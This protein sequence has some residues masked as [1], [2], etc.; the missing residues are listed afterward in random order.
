MLIFR[1]GLCG[2]QYLLIVAWVALVVDESLILRPGFGPVGMRFVLCIGG[3]LVRIS[4]FLSKAH[5]LMYIL[6]RSRMNIF[7]K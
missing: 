4:L 1:I 3:L 2:C 6:E 7:H 5:Y